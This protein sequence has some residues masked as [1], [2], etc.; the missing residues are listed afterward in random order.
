M[1]GG[2]AS[3]AVYEPCVSHACC[4]AFICSLACAAQVKDTK[5][6]K[7]KL[8]VSEPKLGSAIQEETSIPCIA[9]EMVRGGCR[10]CAPC[11]WECV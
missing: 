6:A 5:K 9:N 10:A 8:G 3:K 1:G 7:F 2:R 4:Q 11:P